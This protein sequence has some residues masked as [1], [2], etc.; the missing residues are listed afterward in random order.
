MATKEVVGGGMTREAAAAVQKASEA[1][2]ILFVTRDTPFAEVLK[3]DGEG[4]RV[5]FDRAGTGLKVRPDEATGGRP[6]LRGAAAEKK[7][8]SF[9]WPSSNHVCSK[10]KKSALGSPNAHPNIQTLNL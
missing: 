7:N 5:V 1:R 10:P 4:A 3:C 6:A 9:A 8:L 2:E